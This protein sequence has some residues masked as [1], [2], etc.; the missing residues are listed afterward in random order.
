VRSLAQQYLQINHQLRAPCV[1]THVK[2]QATEWITEVIKNMVMTREVNVPWEWTQADSNMAACKLL[3]F[4]LLLLLKKF[5]CEYTVFLKQNTNCF[6][7]E[8][9]I[10]IF[11]ILE[12]SSLRAAPKPILPCVDLSAAPPI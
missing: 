5:F 8:L 10:E 2:S 12:V 7:P 9:S 6:P 4:L 3:L 1:F 11:F